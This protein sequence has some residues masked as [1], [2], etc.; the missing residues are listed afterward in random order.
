MLQV[1]D[2]L[3]G[4]SQTVIKN[5]SVDVSWMQCLTAIIV[6]MGDLLILE[7]RANSISK[8]RW[9]RRGKRA[10]TGSTMSTVRSGAAHPTKLTL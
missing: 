6:G 5:Y 4:Q 10:A 1:M 8:S 9:K 3:V 7:K 2:S